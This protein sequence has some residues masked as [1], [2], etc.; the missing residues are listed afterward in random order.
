[1]GRAQIFIDDVMIGDIKEVPF[2]KVSDQ[3]ESGI[4]RKVGNISGRI[5]VI[6]FDSFFLEFE[7]LLQ[8]EKYVHDTLLIRQGIE[9]YRRNR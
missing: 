2:P 1:M 5:N 3:A 9:N 6:K 4:M 7:L 8:R